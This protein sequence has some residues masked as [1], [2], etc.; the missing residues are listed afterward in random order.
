[1]Q[2]TPSFLED[3][4][5]QIPALQLLIK[6]GYEYLAPEKSFKERKEKSSQVL[7]ENILES[8]LHNLNEF[9]YNGKTR[10]FSNHNITEAIQSLKRIPF[11][12]LI[13]T[14]FNAVLCQHFPHH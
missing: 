1:M 8:Q 13:R 6:L 3:H 12:G 10:K 2:D 5:S 14:G 9:T 11:D 4:I 7:L